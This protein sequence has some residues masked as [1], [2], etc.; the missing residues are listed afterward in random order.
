M[1]SSFLR[2]FRSDLKLR[3]VEPFFSLFKDREEPLSDLSFPSDFEEMSGEPD[4]EEGDREREDREG[5]KESPIVVLLLDLFVISSDGSV[6]LLK[7]SLSSILGRFK[8]L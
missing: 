4:E 3:I 5:A 7:F 1:G 6:F 2:L 8:V